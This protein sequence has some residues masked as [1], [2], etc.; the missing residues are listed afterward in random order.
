MCKRERERERERRV[1]AHEREKR[2]G[3]MKFAQALFAAGCAVLL[4]S[5]LAVDTDGLTT[6]EK[7]SRLAAC[8]ARRQAAMRARA[9]THTT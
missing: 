6:E 4:G 3:G 9:R 8:W 1:G 5:G 2:V 7:V